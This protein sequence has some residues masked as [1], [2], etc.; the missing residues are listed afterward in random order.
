LISDA[1]LQ[2]ISAI[3]WDVQYIFAAEGSC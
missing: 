1:T 3:E 2:S